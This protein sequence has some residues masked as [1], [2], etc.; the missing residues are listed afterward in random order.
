MENKNKTYRVVWSETKSVLV[1]AED[2]SEAE[3][4]AMDAFYEYATLMGQDTEDIVEGALPVDTEKVYTMTEG[5]TEG[6][7]PYDEDADQKVSESEAYKQKIIDEY[8]V[9]DLDEDDGEY[10][11]KDE[12]EESDTHLDPDCPLCQA[13]AEE[14]GIQLM[15]VAGGDDED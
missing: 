7:C 11:F 3:M 6:Y 15:G 12:H 10:P 13:I 14:R 9:S 1:R 2:E 4:L 8:A 5:D